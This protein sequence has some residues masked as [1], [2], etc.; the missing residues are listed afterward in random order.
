MQ[1]RIDPNICQGHAV[2]HL[3]AP[4]VF[5]IPDDGDG[6]AEVALPDVPEEFEGQVGLAVENCPERAILLS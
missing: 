2:C 6:R 1:V 5:L 4:E 3:S